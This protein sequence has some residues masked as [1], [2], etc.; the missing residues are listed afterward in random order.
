MW[1]KLLLSKYFILLSLGALTQFAVAEDLKCFSFAQR[2]GP[3]EVIKSSKGIL[4]GTTV[5]TTLARHHVIPFNFLRDFFNYAATVKVDLTL[6]SDMDQQIRHLVDSYVDAPNIIT[7]AMRSKIRAPTEHETIIRAI[8]VFYSW[9][10]GNIF[11]GPTP[12]IRSDDPKEEFEI[13][14]RPII[15]DAN[16]KRL[17]D[18]YTRMVNFME[19]AS[20]HNIYTFNLITEDLL[21]LFT[22][23]T[24]FAYNQKQWEVD[25][26]Q[27]R[28]YRIRQTAPPPPSPRKRPASTSTDC[29]ST[30]LIDVVTPPFKK[31]KQ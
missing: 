11:Y 31:L 20:H 23:R 12:D 18:L 25:P 22:H 21:S 4:P 8:Q 10:P 27:A 6:R 16:F 14:C 30:H 9:L 5:M 17:K 19:D 28:K 7:S 24:P 13:D 15:G 2:P 3:Q 1:P 29:F 26:T